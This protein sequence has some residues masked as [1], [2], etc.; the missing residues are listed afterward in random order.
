MKDN[1]K[2]RFIISGG[3]TGG[4]LFPALAIAD[5]LKTRFI[6]PEILFV[7]AKGRME[8][9]RVP[10]AGYEIIGLWIS[11]FQRGQIAKN[12]LL[13]FKIISSL[14]KASRILKKFK[15][16]V[17]IGT[18]G[19]ASVPLIHSASRKGIPTLIQEQNYFPGLANKFLS[20]KA[21]KVCVPGEGL[22]KY[23]DKNKIVI[24]GNPTRNSIKN[25]T[26][27]KAEA[28]HH[29]GLSEDKKTL[30]V[31]GGSLGARTINEALLE[32]WE[33]LLSM[34]LQIIWQTGKTYFEDIKQ[35][36]TGGH[37]TF[38]ILPFIDDMDKAYNAADM[39]ICRAGAITLAELA[40]LGIPSILVPSPNVTDDHQ[41]KNALALQ[42]KEAA[43][44]IKDPN[45]KELLVPKITELIRN[46]NKV[47]SLA[48]NIKKLARPDATDKIVD[49]IEK[50]IKN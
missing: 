30:L 14:M 23:F 46:E 49:E 21:Q 19:Y 50:L 22:E 18:G 29:F 9:E 38:V 12:L 6:E 17:A 24:T 34:D 7:G 2:Y 16:H 36:V 15:P 28:L 3:G 43:I 26:I 8:M 45:L 39:V 33:R 44:M 20:K 13:P 1:I 25:I 48:I 11:G 4:H 10:K 5:K 41:T 40:I 27:S 35:K 37:N 47:N 32:S 42:E 31:V